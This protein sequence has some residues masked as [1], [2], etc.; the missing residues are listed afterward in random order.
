[1]TDQVSKLNMIT[2]QNKTPLQ[3]H[4]LTLFLQ[5]SRNADETTLYLTQAAELIPQLL[6]ID[7]NRPAHQN[8]IQLLEEIPTFHPDLQTSIIMGL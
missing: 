8:L 1:M 5:E 6:E 7:E 2:E 3:Q 4:V